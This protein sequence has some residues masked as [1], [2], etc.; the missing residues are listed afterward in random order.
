MHEYF[1]S[2]K[3]VSSCLVDENEIAGIL[4][5]IQ[6]IHLIV[7]FIFRTFLFYLAET[8]VLE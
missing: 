6:V 3:Q 5:F 4:I 2:D 8:K 7:K 1:I